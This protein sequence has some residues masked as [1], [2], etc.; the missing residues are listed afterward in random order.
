MYRSAFYLNELRPSNYCKQ[1]IEDT[2][3]KFFHWTNWKWRSHWFISAW[4]CGLFQKVRIRR[5]EEINKTYIYK[6]RPKKPTT[7]FSW[8][9][10]N[11]LTSMVVYS[12]ISKLFR[13]FRIKDIFF[14]T[15]THKYIVRWMTIFLFLIGIVFLSFSYVLLIISMIINSALVQ[16]FKVH[17]RV[18]EVESEAEK[19]RCNLECRSKKKFY[20]EK[21]YARMINKS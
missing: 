16:I 11:R 20:K 1:L 18:D 17:V 19:I 4:F 8:L 12:D 14:N 10:S 21:K 9:L 2:N 5:V 13:H 15:L 3:R 7:C 6:E